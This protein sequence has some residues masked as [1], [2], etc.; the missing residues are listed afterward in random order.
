MNCLINCAACENAR[1]SNQV[2]PTL[3]KAILSQMKRYACV[4]VGRDDVGARSYEVSMSLNNPIWPFKKCL[5]RPLGLAKG[6]AN[7]LEF[8]A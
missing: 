6:R 2:A 7:P 3:L 8:A 1:Q 5:R 4:G